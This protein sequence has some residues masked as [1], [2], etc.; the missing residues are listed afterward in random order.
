MPSEW[1]IT[2][3]PANHDTSRGEYAVAL[4]WTMTKASEK[5]RPVS[6]SVPDAIAESTAIAPA[7]FPPV[8]SGRK[9]A[10]SLGTRKPRA[11]APAA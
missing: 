7:V 10:S 5:T 9:R 8:R 6:G 2:P 3:E 1:S 4:N 11:I